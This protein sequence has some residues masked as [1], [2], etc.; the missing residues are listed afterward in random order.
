MRNLQTEMLQAFHNYEDSVSPRFQRMKA[1]LSNVSAETELR[2]NA[3]EKRMQAM[4]KRLG[5]HD[6]Q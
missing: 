4:E 3:L 1:D 5:P 6:L 2:L